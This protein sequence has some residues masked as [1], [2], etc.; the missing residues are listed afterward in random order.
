MNIVNSALSQSNPGNGEFFISTQNTR[1]SKSRRSGWFSIARFGE[2]RLYSLGAK[3]SGPFESLIQFGCLVNSA[4]APST[5][6]P[7]QGAPRYRLLCKSWTNWCCEVLE[8]LLGGGSQLFCRSAW[9]VRTACYP[10][11]P[12][13]S[14]MDPYGEKASKPLKYMEHTNEISGFLSIWIIYGNPSNIGSYRYWFYW[15]IKSQRFLGEFPQ[16]F[17]RAAQLIPEFWLGEPSCWAIWRDEK[18][19]LISCMYVYIYI[20]LYIY[21]ISSYIIIYHHISSY[22]IIYHHIS[23]YI[24]IYH[25]I[26]SYIIIYYHIHHISSYTSSYHMHTW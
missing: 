11:I 12:K 10:A 6:I 14:H 13:N 20:F 3:R 1:Y 24:I 26:S 17:A 21:H 5:G 2:Y 9:R 25:H 19:T 23:S 16:G 18:N 22:I 4:C 15:P 8:T 7:R